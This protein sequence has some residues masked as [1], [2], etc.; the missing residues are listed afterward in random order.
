MRFFNDKSV[1]KHLFESLHKAYD[2]PFYDDSGKMVYSRKMRA[3]L[4]KDEGALEKLAAQKFEEDLLKKN[5]KSKEM[6]SIE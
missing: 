6:S 5:E 4:V 3:Y 2:I 1:A